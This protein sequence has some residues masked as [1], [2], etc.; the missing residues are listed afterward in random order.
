[1]NWEVGLY[2]IAESMSEDLLFLQAGRRLLYLQPLRCPPSKNLEP[3]V[4][5]TAPLSESDRPMASSSF[6]R[7]CGATRSKDS[8]R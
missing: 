4:G 2:E 6:E 3:L 5:R 8:S 7:K 1:M